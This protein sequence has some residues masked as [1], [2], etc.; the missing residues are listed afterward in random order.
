MVSCPSRKQMVLC[1]FFH[2]FH[3]YMSKATCHFCYIVHF[4]V[5]WGTEPY[6][7]RQP[8]YIRILLLPSILNPSPAVLRKKELRVIFTGKP[9]QSSDNFFDTFQSQ[10]KKRERFEVI[11]W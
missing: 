4:R 9:Y 1:N 7:A 5:P 10:P 2:R 8:L 3:D 11:I 6:V